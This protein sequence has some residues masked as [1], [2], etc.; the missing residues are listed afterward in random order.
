MAHRSPAL[1]PSEIETALP[2]ERARVV[3]M[4]AEAG[5]QVS[6]RAT[7]LSSQQREWLAGPALAEAV[8][9]FQAYPRETEYDRIGRRAEDVLSRLR[10]TGDAGW[11]SI[12]WRLL[13]L[14][15]LARLSSS[16]LDLRV[17]VSCW[18]FFEDGLQSLL[19]AMSAAEPPPWDEVLFRKDVAVAQLRLLPDRGIG[20]GVF[21]ANPWFILR[22]ATWRERMS[23]VHY[24][25]VGAF[26]PGLYLTGHGWR[27]LF[28]DG[29]PSDG[30]MRST[31][32]TDLML[33]NPAIRGT[34]GGGWT[35]DPA[36]KTVTP[37]LWERAQRFRARGGRTFRMPTHEIDVFHAL[38]MSEHRRT[39]Y[40]EGKYRPQ[41]HGEILKR[42]DFIRATRVEEH[43]AANGQP[44]DSQ[45]RHT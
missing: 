28:R 41:V 21:K 32:M 6:V 5:A 16:T 35:S 4:A 24:L 3:R 27:E 17:P 11:P 18:P 1:P 12:F 39:L 14:S 36:L 10:T 45:S 44:A 2:R 40:A 38:Q 9:A 31:S 29:R 37:H 8:H 22:E 26:R 19:D 13:T 20:R 23:V 15:L 34:L 30:G 43:R 33:A 42:G 25:G 7:A